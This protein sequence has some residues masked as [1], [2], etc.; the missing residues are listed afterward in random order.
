MLKEPLGINGLR[1]ASGKTVT[2]NTERYVSMSDE[3]FDEENLWELCGH[4][5]QQDG[6]PAHTFARFSQKQVSSEIDLP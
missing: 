2:V 3:I 6:V 1:P 4:C 5:F